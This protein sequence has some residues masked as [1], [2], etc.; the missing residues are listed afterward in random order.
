MQY[1]SSLW[2]WAWYVFLMTWWLWDKVCLIWIW[3]VPILVTSWWDLLCVSG[4]M[5]LHIYNAQVDVKRGYDVVSLCYEYIRT[6]VC[7]IWIIVMIDLLQY[8]NMNVSLYECWVSI[9]SRY[10]MYDHG[11]LE[12]IF[13]VDWIMRSYLC[14][15][16]E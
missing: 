10:G 14:T 6:Y 5:W 1:T 8:L 7:M 3:K 9:R 16:Q 4:S 12:V 11:G 2:V 13:S 15:V